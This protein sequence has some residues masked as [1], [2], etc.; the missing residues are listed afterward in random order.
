MPELS[1]VGAVGLLVLALVVVGLF[2]LII[3]SFRKVEQGQAIIR[4]GLGGSKVSLSGMIVLPIIHKAELMDISVKRVEIER[5]GK[6]GLIC[7]DNMRADIKVAFF[8]KVNQKNHKDVLDVAMALGTVKASD[9]TALLEFFDAKFSEALKTVGKKFD[10]EQLYTDRQDFKREILEVIGKDLNGYIFEDCAIDYLEQTDVHEL[11]ADNIL[12]SEGIKKIHDRTAA[13][14]IRANEI[15]RDKEKTIKSQ[16]VAAREAIL[17]LEKQQQEAEERQKREVANIKSRE[18]ADAAKVGEEE[19]LK[20]ERARISTEEEVAIAEEN[21]LRQ[22]IVAQKAKERTDAIE[23][24]RVDKER[25]LEKTEKEKIV[26]L[27]EI[28]KEKSVEIQRK[29][30]QDVIRERVMVEKEVVIEQERIKDTEA[31]AGADRAKQVAVTDASRQAEESLIRQTKAAEASKLS[32]DF[33][34]E[35]QL[36]EADANLKASEKQAESVKIMAAAKSEEE[37]IVGLSEARV[38]ESKADAFEKEGNAKARILE[39][40]AIAEAKGTEAKAIA[41]EKEGTATANVLETTAMAESK[42]YEAKAL[43]KAKGTEANAL[44]EAK[45]AETMLVA[46]AKG[47]EAKATALEKEGTAEASVM[48]KK[49]SAEA[50]GVAEKANAMKLLDGVGKEHEEFKLK[51]EKEKEIDLAQIDIQRDIAEA[52]ASVIN[53]ALRSAKIDI[54]GGETMFFDKIVGSITQGKSIDRM[55]GNSDVLS[56][57]KKTLITGDQEYFKNQINKFINQFGIGSEDLKNLTLSGVLM[58]MG[59]SADAAD[60]NTLEELL[61]S[62]TKAGFADLPAKLLSK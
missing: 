44:A 38:I 42:G 55:V 28:E 20:S 61:E 24:E 37:A 34:C 13:Q 52:Q 12:D 62:V 47:Q 3:R 39:A 32:A 31:F 10:F 4:N 2:V 48:A 5:T 58:K 22:V 40:T 15:M 51:L 6:D 46:E 25:L 29:N 11:N 33:N 53:E 50:A 43:A 30:I 26:T 18:V 49:Y 16:D 57:V 27:A 7:K 54:V 21:K 23:T 35:K 19:R 8:V 41:L 1:S 14:A 45:G 36:V 59:R 56:D 60:K 9:E 17:E